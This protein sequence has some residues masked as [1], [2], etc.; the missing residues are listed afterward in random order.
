MIEFETDV[1]RVVIKCL[2]LKVN[3][4][5]ITKN[6]GMFSNLI[7]TFSGRQIPKYEKRIIKLSQSEPFKPGGRPPK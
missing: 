6:A 2:G 5:A 3:V 1:T 4:K 7:R